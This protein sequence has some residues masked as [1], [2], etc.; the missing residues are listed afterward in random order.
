MRSSP[1]DAHNAI[2]YAA[3]PGRQ[4]GCSFSK[5]QAHDA[6]ARCAEQEADGG[7]APPRDRPAKQQV[8]DVGADDD[9]GEKGDDA[10]HRQEHRS[11]VGDR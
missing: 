11:N 4:T 8:G 3:I 9:Q 7:I 6:P 10:E 1:R 2:T 5:D